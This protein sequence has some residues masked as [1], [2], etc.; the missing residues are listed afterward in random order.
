VPIGLAFRYAPRSFT[1]GQSADTRTPAE[2]NRKQLEMLAEHRELFE[3]V[4]IGDAAR[5]EELRGKLDIWF[6]SD[7]PRYQ[8]SWHNGGGALFGC[9]LV[10]YY[11]PNGEADLPADFFK[12]PSSKWYHTMKIDD[13]WFTAAEN[14]G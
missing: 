3:A 7:G 13:H 5:A 2:K 11:C 9:T 6:G 10:I 12:T 1:A 4:A 8:F 14:C